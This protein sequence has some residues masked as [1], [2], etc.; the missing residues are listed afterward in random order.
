MRAISPQEIHGALAFAVDR[1]AIV[2]GILLGVGK[3][4]YSSIATN[5]PGYE[6]Q[7][8]RFDFDPDKAKELLAST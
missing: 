3:V 5:S 1:Q 8:E 4:P 2:D 7:P 6:E